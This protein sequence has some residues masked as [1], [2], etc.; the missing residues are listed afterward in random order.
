MAIAR[1]APMSPDPQSSVH[2][3]ALIVGSGPVGCAFARRL[4]EAGRKVLM[5]DAG[6][7]L[8]DRP[9]EHLKNAYL[10]QRNLDLF[11][12]VIRGHLA[13]LSLPSNRQPVITLDPAAFHVDAAKYRGFV[14]NNQNPD[15]DPSLNLPAAA[16]SYVVGGMATHWTCATP[17][18]H[19]VVERA[20]CLTTE[21]WDDLYGQAEALLNTRT[22]A[23]EH[24]VRHQVVRDA[25]Q[26]EYRELPEP[27]HVQNLPLAV[28]RRTD[29][30]RFVRWT[31]SD[32]VLGPLADG[33]YPDRFDLRPQHLCRRL[34]RSSEGGRIEYAEVQDLADWKTLRVEA[35]DYI[36]ACGA[37]LTPQLLYASEIRPDTLGRYLCEQP[38]AFCQIVLDQG[39]VDAVETDPRF[40]DAVRAHTETSP[41][42]PVPI[43]G[44]DPEPNVWIPLSEA[45]PWH[46]QIHRDAF[47][48]GEVAPNVDARLIVDLR[49]FGY[50]EPRRENRVI[51]SD[52][53][54]DL[55]GMPQPTFE[56]T[57]SEQDRRR[58]HLM[59]RDMLRAASVLGGFLPGSEPRFVDPGLPLHISG[60]TRIGTDP[61]TSLVDLDSRV[62]GIDNLY[63]GGNGLIPTGNAS[64][65]TLTSVALA[66][67]SARHILSPTEG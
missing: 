20:D 5:L 3:D 18:H 26:A 10:Y 45:R 16:A 57:L 50:A 49:W 27:Y 17:R 37:V 59:M 65:P 64:N 6:P 29:N 46:S 54:H 60:T 28:E 41:V 53:H 23:F 51:F 25:L 7:K 33:A 31:G 34:H 61:E 13:L 62:W 44:D 42:D 32:T 15:Q 12:S 56:F 38:V 43:P 48:Y 40:M 1:G 47:H 22:D 67:R 55:F 52:V 8:S 36:V 11:S 63:L 19:H 30:R 39:L 14:H 35:D 21:E 4:V 2:V 24:S 66:L 9:G 58:Q